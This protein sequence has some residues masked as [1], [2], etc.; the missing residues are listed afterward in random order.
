MS[1]QFD[2]R[3]REILIIFGGSLILVIEALR[4]ARGTESKALAMSKEATQMGLFILLAVLIAEVIMERGSIV[5]WSGRPAK[6]ALERMLLELIIFVSLLLIIFVNI[7]F[8]VSRS[9]MGLVRLRSCCQF[10]FLGME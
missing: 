4:L 1:L 9:A 6:F 10:L 5:L 8:V 3:L 2:S 7:F